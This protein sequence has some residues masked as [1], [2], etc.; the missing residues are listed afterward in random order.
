MHFFS[1]KCKVLVG[2]KKMQSAGSKTNRTWIKLSSRLISNFQSF[3]SWK[4]FKCSRKCHSFL[5]N[6][7]YVGF[8]MGDFFLFFTLPPLLPVLDSHLLPV[9]DPHL[10]VILLLLLQQHGEDLPLDGLGKQ[11]Q[12]TGNL[13]KRSQIAQERSNFRRCP[14]CQVQSPI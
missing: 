10:P 4:L 12:R 9:L 5:T 13:E 1:S 11:D 14:D 6:N 7:L 3:N 8:K 2:K